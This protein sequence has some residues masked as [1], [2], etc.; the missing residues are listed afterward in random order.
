MPSGVFISTSEMG[1]GMRELR[2][3]RFSQ[4]R[5]SEGAAQ[6]WWEQN[7]ERILAEFCINNPPPVSR[8]TTKGSSATPQQSPAKSGRSPPGTGGKKYQ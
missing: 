6:K 1:Q 2:R 4:R 8:I 3:V 7:R 5:F